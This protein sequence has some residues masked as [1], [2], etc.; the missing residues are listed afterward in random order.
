MLKNL[1]NLIRQQLQVGS[2]RRLT[3]KPLKEVNRGLKTWVRSQT[4]NYTSKILESWFSQMPGIPR[5]LKK[6]V[7]TDVLDALK[8][9]ILEN[10]AGEFNRKVGYTAFNDV[11]SL[12]KKL[13]TNSLTQLMLLYS[14]SKAGL[15]KVLLT[16]YVRMLPSLINE[17]EEK[18]L[19]N[20][21][22]AVLKFLSSLAPFKKW[23][24][25]DVQ[26]NGNILNF[27][28]IPVAAK[29]PHSYPHSIEFFEHR[30]R[31]YSQNNAIDAI[32]V[33]AIGDINSMV[34]E[35]AAISF[36]QK[37]IKNFTMSMKNNC[38]F[39]TPHGMKRRRTVIFLNRQLDP[40]HLEMRAQTLKK[41]SHK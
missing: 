10:T 2:A 26:F 3:N 39:Y 20:E 6:C 7:D 17:A 22:V 32:F 33:V 36:Y 1:V 21:S 13:D 37:N 30:I 5:G 34:A 14:I 9:F 38:K 31:E 24:P 35:N 23:N 25:S 18:R 11:K 29:Y 28:I 40:S 19:K 12:R 41:Q 15:L 16:I 8:I 27:V 4:E